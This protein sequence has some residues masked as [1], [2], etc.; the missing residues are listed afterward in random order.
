MIG[1]EETARMIDREKLETGR[2]PSSVLPIEMVFGACHFDEPNPGL[3]LLVYRDGVRLYGECDRRSAR[4]S[5]MYW[6]TPFLGPEV[7]GDLLAIFAVSHPL[8]RFRIPTDEDFWLE[9][10]PEGE[11]FHRINVVT[12]LF[13]GKSGG[14][15]LDDDESCGLHGTSVTIRVGA[16]RAFLQAFGHAAGEFSPRGARGRALRTR[17]RDVRRLSEARVEQLRFERERAACQRRSRDVT[18]LGPYSVCKHWMEGLDWTTSNA[19]WR[20][21]MD[22]DAGS[23]LPLRPQLTDEQFSL[24]AFLRECPG[25]WNPEGRRWLVHGFRIVLC[26]MGTSEWPIERL[27]RVM[28]ELRELGLVS[29]DGTGSRYPKSDCPACGGEAG[30]HR[31]RRGPCDAVARPITETS[32]WTPGGPLG[33]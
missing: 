11:W 24:Y 25:W 32:L 10:C 1:E 4:D 27:E 23:L 3:G 12:S 26:G 7:L 18:G 28:G 15:Y 6:R 8:S 21:R 20:E 16:F 30:A 13:E 19:E 2:R 5:K 22:A 14:I 29:A 31:E 17:M 33:R 9:S